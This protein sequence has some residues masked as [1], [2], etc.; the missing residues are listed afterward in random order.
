MAEPKSKNIFWHGAN[1]TSDERFDLVGQKG[2]VLWF[3]GLS[4]SGKST[5]ARRVEELILRR[6]KISYALDGDNLRMGLNNDLGFSPADRTENI[7][8]IGQVAKLFADAGVITTTSFISPYRA[9]RD[10]AREILPEGSFIEV[11]VNTPL[12]VC[13]SRDPKGLHAKARAGIIPNFTGISA[14][15]EEPTSPEI[16]L[17]TDGRSI[18]DC[19]GEV[20]NYLVANGFLAE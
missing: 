8:R 14:P 15:Y 13:E 20:V 18:D 11:F 9:G 4:G 5:V 3:T 2:C 7:R 19:A 16:N 12:A 10:A 1:V 6:G 17:M